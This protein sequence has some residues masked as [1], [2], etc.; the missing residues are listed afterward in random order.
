MTVKRAAE[1]DHDTRVARGIPRRAMR[2][3]NMHGLLISF[4]PLPQPD[5]DSDE[6]GYCQF[7]VACRGPHGSYGF[8]DG[9]T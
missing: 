8:C 6:D 7:G 1:T 5:L 2:R 4:T 3:L 9:T